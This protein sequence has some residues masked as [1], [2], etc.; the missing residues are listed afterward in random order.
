MAK[1]KKGILGA[2][3]G[4]IGPVIGGMWKGISF[5]REVPKAIKRKSTP[6]QIESREKLKYMNNLL[7]PFHPYINIGFMH[8]AE[9]RT[10]I[11]AAFSK[12]YSAVTG[13]Y[14]E[15]TVVYNEFVISMGELPMVTDMTIEL[16]AND[17]IDLTW[18]QNPGKKTSFDDHLMLVVYCPELHITD[19]FVGGIKRTDKHCTFKFNPKMIGKRLEVYLSVTSIDRKKVGNSLHLGTL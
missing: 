19:G 11:S 13:Q 3:S 7:V 1:I 9:R 5:I 10:E 6:A 4:K 18:K 17:T 14:P 12:N 8:H 2:F 16:S 15:Y